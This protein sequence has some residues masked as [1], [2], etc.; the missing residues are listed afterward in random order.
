MEAIIGGAVGAVSGAVATGAA[1]LGLS[2]A[3]F[4]AGGVVAGSLAAGAQAGIGNVVA[5]SLFAG[6][7]SVAATGAVLGALPVVAGV[8][9]V[10]GVGVGAFLAFT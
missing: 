6:L 1:A 5:G 3:G 7:Q 8:T 4:G 10:I 9:A 2:A